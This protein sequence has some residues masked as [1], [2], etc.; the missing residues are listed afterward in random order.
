MTASTSWAPMRLAESGYA[1]ALIRVATSFARPSST[2]LTA[3]TRPP[4]MTEWM[5]SMCAWPMPPGPI[6]PI[7]TVIAVTPSSLEAQADGGEVLAGLD[8]VGQRVGRVA[9]IHVLLAHHV[10]LLV[11]VVQGLDVDVGDALGVFAAQLHRV[12]AAVDDVAGVEAEADVVGVGGLEDAVDVLG[13]LD[14]AVP[15]RVQHHPEAVVLLHDATEPVGVGDVGVPGFRRQN[16]VVGELPRLVVAEERRQV[17]DVLRADGGVRLGDLTERLLRVGPG[18][19][20]VQ[21][22]P[23]GAGDDAEA[24]L[25]HLLL[26]ALG[27]LGEV[28]ER[29]G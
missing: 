13:R 21:D 23:A 7:R 29:P 3:T 8:G 1:V 2:S 28:A 11:E 17:H 9:G 26:E 10:E 25:V 18:L 22:A 14:V 16:T 4:A 24:P 6:I 27:V 15:V 5:R 19:G 12:A 20:L